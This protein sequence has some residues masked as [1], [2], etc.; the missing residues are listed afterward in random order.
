MITRKSILALVVAS[1]MSFGASH[2][3]ETDKAAKKP[4]VNSSTLNSKVNA[5]SV[6]GGTL[7]AAGLITS[8]V[9]IY[10]VN[11]LN[12]K[13]KNE[14][15]SE[16]AREEITADRDFFKKGIYLTA[17]LTATGVGFA[18]KGIFWPGEKKAKVVKNNSK[19]SSNKWYNY[20]PILHI[21]PDLYSGIFGK[22]EEKKND[23]K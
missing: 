16:V 7:T 4:E 3:N 20:V 1:L 6:T 21:F 2:A 10:K 18:T 17:A 13:L 22:K 12:K 23:N 19:K 8:A 14:P 5:W 15:L 9:C 11:V